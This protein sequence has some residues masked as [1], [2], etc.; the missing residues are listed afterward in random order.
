MNTLRNNKVI[1]L[2]EKGYCKGIYAIDNIYKINSND[3][4]IVAKRKTLFSVLFRKNLKV[5]GASLFVGE[6]K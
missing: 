6:R 2:K 5:N 4:R 1:D 3:Q